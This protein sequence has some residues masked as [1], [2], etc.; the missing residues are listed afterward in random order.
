MHIKKFIREWVVPIGV[1]IAIAFIIHTF[2][3]FQIK[4]PSSSM[5]PT[6]KIGD[7]IIVTRVY[8]RSN[9]KTGD[10][11]VFYSHELELTLIKRLIGVP[12]DEVKIN[13]SGE[14]F[15]N[16]KQLDQPYVINKANISK[17]FKVPE[18]KYLFFGDNREVSNDAR[19]WKDP[20]IDGKDIEGKAQVIIFPF[21]RLGKFVIGQEAINK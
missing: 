14:V 8:N 1:A 4:V 12:G 13:D 16:G 2:I 20:Y 11:V 10:I 5:Y 7:R 19:W 3:F 21:K 17:N 15:I 6:I 18:G 9:L